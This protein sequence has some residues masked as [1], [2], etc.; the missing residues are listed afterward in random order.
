MKLRIPSLQIPLDDLSRPLPI[1]NSTNA[2]HHGLVRKEVTFRSHGIMLQS[3][4]RR[5]LREA[6]TP[7]S[8]D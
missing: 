1:E 2:P 6:S 8:F 5:V 3:A 4:F 7:D